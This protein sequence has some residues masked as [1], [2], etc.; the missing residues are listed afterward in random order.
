M[1]ELDNIIA[2]E[3]GELNTEDTIVLFAELIKNG[4]AWSLQGHYGR[5]AMALIDAKY[6]SKAGVINWELI[7][8]IE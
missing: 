6:I 3:S 1:S 5:S 7:I 2:Y 4:K 8:E